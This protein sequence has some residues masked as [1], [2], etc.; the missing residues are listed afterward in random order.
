MLYDLGVL[1]IRDGLVVNYANN[2]SSGYYQELQTL[3][4][5]NG[6]HSDLISDPRGDLGTQTPTSSLNGI[7]SLNATTNIV[8]AIEGPNELDADGNY[9]YDGY[10]GFPSNVIA[11][12][13]QLYS[14]FKGNSKTAN[15]TVIGPSEGVTYQES[16]RHPIETRLPPVPCT[17]IAT[18]GIF[19]PIHSG[20]T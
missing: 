12:Q 19:T 10:T 17:T 15:L 1:H 9:T 8:D 6:I 18:S 20:E 11:Y 7:I 13:Q 4:A 2:P 5:N 14:A 3:A 16:R